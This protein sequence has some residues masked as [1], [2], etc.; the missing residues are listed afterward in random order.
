MTDGSLR[1]PALIEVLIATGRW[2]ATDADALGQ[3]LEPLVPAERVAEAAPGEDCLYLYPPPFRSVADELGSIAPSG[4][5]AFWREH[6]A[7]DELDPE[8]AVVIGDFGPGSDTP[9]V[10]DHRAPDGPRVLRLVWPADHGGSD[11]TTWV[12]IAPSF[13]E[14]AR[15][16]GLR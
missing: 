1:P 6:G 10:L 5:R 9:I 13:D 12:E 14:F 8:Q 3:N 15:R 2:P 7:L 4:A 11:T 16:L